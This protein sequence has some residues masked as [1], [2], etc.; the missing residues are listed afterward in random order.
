[1]SC[2]GKIVT[3]NVAALYPLCISDLDPKPSLSASQTEDSSKEIYKRSKDKPKHSQRAMIRKDKSERMSQTT[4]SSG[5][6]ET[7]RL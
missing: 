7:D 3:K 4:N 6:K 5:G 2:V 1:M